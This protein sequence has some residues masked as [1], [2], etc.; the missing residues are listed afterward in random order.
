MGR[1]TRPTR[2]ASALALLPF[3]LSRHYRV[4]ST[5]PTHLLDEGPRG[6]ERLTAAVAVALLLVL[7]AE[8][9]TL[10]VIREA[11]VLH[12]FLGMVLL[13]LTAVK[14]ASTGYRVARYYLG[15][16]PY[17]RRG[18]PAIIPRLLGPAVAGLT[19]ALLVTGVVLVLIP[20]GPSLLLTLHKV[21]FV[22]W[23]SAMTVHVLIHLSDLPGP[24]LA[25]WRPGAARLVGGAGRRAAL[26]A[27][28]ATG[29]VLGLAFLPASAGWAHYLAGGGITG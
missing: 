2:A 25:D 26:G 4:F 16:R 23:F 9:A 3:I 20:A 11:V 6:N 1:Y 28:L 8:G 17:L 7:A 12:I 21:V 22:L 24:G 10:V 27:G 15:S 14:L 29:L 19:V 18:P 5:L 13:S